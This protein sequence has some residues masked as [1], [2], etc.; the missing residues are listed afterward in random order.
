MSSEGLMYLQ[1]RVDYPA[2]QRKLPGIPDHSS[3][4]VTLVCTGMIPVL[5]LKTHAHGSLPQMHQFEQGRSSLI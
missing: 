1:Y 3:A 2:A 4:A 5:R